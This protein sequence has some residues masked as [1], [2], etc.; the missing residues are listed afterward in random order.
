M[1][2]QLGEEAISYAHA[3]K[4]EALVQLGEMLKGMEKS[5][6]GDAQRT[7]FNKGTESPPTLDGQSMPEKFSLQPLTTLPSTIQDEFLI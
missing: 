5:T 7:R 4:I 2:Q 1:R 3:V 6:G